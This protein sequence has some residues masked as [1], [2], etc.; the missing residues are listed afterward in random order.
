MPKDWVPGPA[1]GDG[2][3]FEA[4]DDARL[5]PDA[6]GVLRPV[7]EYSYP[8]DD[9][10]EILGLMQVAGANVDLTSRRITSSEIN[11]PGLQLTGYTDHFASERLQVIGWAETAYLAGLD[12]EVR[13]A[14][15]DQYFSLEFPALVVARGL[16][17]MPDMVGAANA[18][19]VPVFASELNTS[20]VAGRLNW[21][22][23]HALAPRVKIAA[24]LVDVY[25]EGVLI[26]GGAGI[27]KSETALE[28]VRRGHRLISDDRVEVL[29]IADDQ[30]RGRSPDG[31][32]PLILLPGIGAVDVQELFGTGAVKPNAS[33]SMV[34]ALEPRDIDK[35]YE[36]VGIEDR[37]H[38]VF[39]VR[40][41]LVTIP[42]QP[43]RNL[44]VIIEA[45]ALDHRQRSQGY[46]AAADLLN[47]T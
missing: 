32:P 24:G 16:H 21:L 43:G 29:R 40:L 46:N 35:E 45:A 23:L 15:L 7:S 22:L 47:R 28:L 5:P 26:V 6:T 31:A 11:R 14:R 42:V 4:V 19:D 17:V 30:L 1:A 33:V 9:V 25:G 34:V 10:V 38:T 20:D 39:G 44:A 18:H 8:L 41:D 27:G 36:R 13:T 2:P 3:V 12:P 37:T